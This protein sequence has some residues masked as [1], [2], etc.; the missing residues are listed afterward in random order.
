VTNGTLSS[1]RLSDDNGGK[2]VSGRLAVSPV[3]GLVIAGSAARG[4][5]LARSVPRPAGPQ[6]GQSAVG[7]DVEYSRDHWLVR[8]ELVWSR[9]TLPYAVTPNGDHQVR[10]LAAWAEG[11]Y[12]LTPRIFVAA[13]TDRLGF[14]RIQGNLFARAPTP[15]DSPVHRLET[16]A[17]YYL[18]RNLIARVDVQANRRDAGRVKHRTYFSA[19]LSYWF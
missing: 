15:W 8:G 16:G 14:S 4:A 13:R 19:Q 12:R 6:L 1:P 7:T 3:V 5:W 17:G 10:A 2:Q 11:R 18:Q 9:W